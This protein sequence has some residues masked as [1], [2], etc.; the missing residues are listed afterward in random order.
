MLSGIAAV[1][2][3]LEIEY[4]CLP[5]LALATVWWLL[6]RRFCTLARGS[7]GNAG[8]SCW[9]RRRPTRLQALQSGT[10]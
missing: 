9:Q 8:A 2:L 3:I 5:L 6:F 7:G 10:W 4:T 1:L